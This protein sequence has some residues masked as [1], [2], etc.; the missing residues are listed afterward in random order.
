MMSVKIEAR[1]YAL[2]NTIEELKKKN[3]QIEFWCGGCQQASYER[4]RKQL[5]D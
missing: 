2:E 4:F 5:I 3:S 1:E